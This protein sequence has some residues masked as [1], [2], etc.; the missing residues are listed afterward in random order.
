MIKVQA[1]RAIER[2]ASDG[3]FWVFF[4]FSI[5]LLLLLRDFFFPFRGGEVLRRRPRRLAKPAA[6]LLEYL[7]NAASAE[8][9]TGLEDL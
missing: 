9:I 1:V 7:Q 8:L 5:S 4:F 3:E 6:V 2:A